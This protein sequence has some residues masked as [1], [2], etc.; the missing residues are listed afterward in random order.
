MMI[1]RSDLKAVHTLAMAER[2]NQLADASSNEQL[3]AFMRGELSAEETDRVRQFLLA[4]PD[5]IDAMNEPFPED[6]AAPG[7]PGHVSDTEVGRR[8]AELKRELEGGGEVVPFRPRVVFAIA[9]A[10]VLAFGALLWQN[11]ALR[12]DVRAPLLVQDPQV[13]MPSGHRGG[14][15]ER[16]MLRRD[17]EA[18]V[19]A[20]SLLS[21]VDFA[22]FRLEL[23]KAGETRAVWRSGRMAAP[24]DGVFRLAMR[25][26]AIAAGDY[27]LLLYGINGDREELLATYSIRVPEQ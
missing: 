27:D 26:S 16:V 22:S 10:L 1:T 3:F 17:G 19:V 12:R 8:F 4:Y 23:V 20:V 7:E 5:L 24:A 25:H 2:R 9:A 21:Q 18:Y 11:F 14:S 13:L 6:E 15:T